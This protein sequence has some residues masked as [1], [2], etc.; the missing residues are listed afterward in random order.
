M[1]RI[2][3]ISTLLFLAAGLALGAADADA[4]RT[5][6]KRKPAPAKVSTENKK[7]MTELMGV[8][9]FGMSKDDVIAALNK[10]LD[11]RYAEQIA[12]TS[13]IY[14]QD[15]LR[16]EKKEEQGRISQSYVAFTG[17]KTGWDVSIIDTEF[18]H[19]TG[20][21]MLVYWEN[22]GGKNQRRFFFF[23]EDQLYKMFIAL[24]TK[25]VSEEQRSFDFF[26]NLMEQRFGKGKAESGKETWRAD[27][28]EV[29]ALD[30]I[31]FYDAFCLVITDPK[32]AQRVDQEREAKKEPKQAGNQI[33]KAVTEKGPEDRPS[34]DAQ[35]DVLDKIIKEPKAPK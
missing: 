21:S 14:T 22:Q 18:A 30:R 32:V 23:F 24:D 15:K 29:K 10:Q 31:Q 11:E 16:R 8:F 17:K 13:D 4:G 35:K 26:R 27:S 3:T 1:S 19:H 28:F 25:Q 6:K 33:L 5:G 34:L 12:A 2:K 20:E 9:K 7:A